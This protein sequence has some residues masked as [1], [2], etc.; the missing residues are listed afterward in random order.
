MEYRTVI[1]TDEV[2]TNEPVERDI[3]ESLIK[4][5]NTEKDTRYGNLSIT[6]D[7]GDYDVLEEEQETIS[8]N[9]IVW[10]KVKSKYGKED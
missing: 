2:S 8:L 1:D 3:T 6:G 5:V 10:F 4:T 7:Y 9:D